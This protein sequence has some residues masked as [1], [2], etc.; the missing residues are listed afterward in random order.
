VKSKKYRSVIT[1]LVVL[2][3]LQ[4][5]SCPVTLGAMTATDA[6]GPSKVQSLHRKGWPSDVLKAVFALYGIEVVEVSPLPASLGEVTVDFD[7]AD[8]EMAASM[9]GELTHRFFVPFDA[10]LV[11]AVPD[12]KANR[13]RF[14]QPRTETILVPNML[15]TSTED[16]GSLNGLL[17]GVFGDV[18]STINGNNVTVRASPQECYQIRKLLSGLY[19]PRAQVVLDVKAYLISR[20]HDR[21]MGIKLPQKIVIFNIATEAETLITSNSAVVEEL[22]SA[23][24]V[25]AGDTLGIAELLVADGY[26]GNSVLG[27]SSVYF[28]GGKTATGL[29][30]DSAN[31]NASLSASTVRELQDAKLQLSDGQVGAFR[32]GQRYPVVTATSTAVGSNYTTPIIQYEDLGLT[33]EAKPHVLAG[34]EV[35]VHLHETFRALNGVSLNNIPIID[36][37]EISTDLTV[38][39]GVTTVLVSNLSRTETLETEDLLGV[40]PSNASR[41]QVGSQLVIT[42]T[43]T[44]TRTN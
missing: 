37:R 22:I 7:D 40:V 42:V 41:D 1:W 9:I 34:Q 5:A 24:L 25:S 8:I 19:R 31:V 13:T 2:A 17:L 30:F 28:G 11:L 27:S 43:P 20:T 23:G 29:Q 32:V 21:D 44:L 6:N 35:L 26:A 10:H 15:S 33:L 16:R 18:K 36:N 3:W 4:C 39:E 14:E 12:D 38:P